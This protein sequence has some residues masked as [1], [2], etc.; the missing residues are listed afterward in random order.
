MG[1]LNVTHVDIQGVKE[2]FEKHKDEVS[3]GIK[4]HFN[5][6]DSGILNVDKVK[7]SIE[8]QAKIH[9]LS[10]LDRYCI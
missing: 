2:V 1:S 8:Q 7:T 6:D 3:K 5:M 9:Y 10:N 4:V